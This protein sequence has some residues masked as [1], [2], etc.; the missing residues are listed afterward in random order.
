MI[1]RTLSEKSLRLLSPIHAAMQ[2]ADDPDAV[3]R[4]A[5]EYDP[6]IERRRHHEKSQVAQFLGTKARA[7]THFRKVAEQIK[8]FK[9]R[10]QKRAGRNIIVAPDV[11]PALNQVIIYFG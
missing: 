2:D 9:S 4:D 10:I 5:I 6:P 11:I 8:R 1:V 3:I 7:R